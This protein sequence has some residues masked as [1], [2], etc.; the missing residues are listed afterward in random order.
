MIFSIS[1]RDR[2]AFAAENNNNWKIECADYNALVL[3]AHLYGSSQWKSIHFTSASLQ[4]QT[5]EIRDLEFIQGNVLK[6]S[7]E[8]TEY[9]YLIDVTA[10]MQKKNIEFSLQNI[11]FRMDFCL[12]FFMENW[13][14]IPRVRWHTGS[15]SHI[16]W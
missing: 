10:S 8:G 11:H 15:N 3:K 5:G 14:L 4:T 9:I 12:L 13:L 2:C 1:L 7:G 6:T 16:A